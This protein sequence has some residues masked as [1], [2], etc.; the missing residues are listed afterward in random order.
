[1]TQKSTKNHYV[2]FRSLPPVMVWGGLEKLMLEWFERIDLSK[3]RVTLVVST[4][5]GELYEKHIRD[6]GL[7]VDVVEFPF[8]TDFKY[9]DGFLG[10]LFKTL[11]LLNSL[12]PNLVMFFQ[13]SFTDFDLAHVM[14]AFMKAKGQVFMHENLGAPQPSVKSS[15]K[16]LGF[17]PGIALW[18]YYERYSMALR[19]RFCKRIY[20]VSAE[21]RQR[22]I[23]LW[24]YPA[25]KI[26]VMYHGVDVARFHPSVDV[27]GDMR[28]S[29]GIAR[30]DRV[31]ILAARL[32]QEKCIDR[33]I[34]AFDDLCREYSGL[35]L[36][37]AGTGPYEE[38]LRALA[39]GKSS[40]DKIKFLGQVTNVHEFYQMSDIYVLS[41]DNEGL[42]LAFLEAL[43][44]GLVCVVTKC[45]GTTEV[46]EDGVNGFLVEKNSV[47]VLNGLRKA[48][49]LA[50]EK[51]RHIS[52]NAVHFV[53][54]RFEINRNVA[55]ALSKFGIPLK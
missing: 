47:G 33:A 4:G 5:W 19:A 13:G 49:S 42:S 25:D 54:E 35:H 10:R 9:T 17:I 40:R 51:S 29:M 26:E 32:S 52:R 38:R 7:T 36:V 50:D 41:S 21:I 45:T 39:A 15:R 44:S 43:A 53:N 23:D 12:K 30:S 11:G 1:M 55:G 6:N 14:A 46:I 8:R 31:I 48:L 34:N 16:Y 18:W 27:K 20:V 2:F 22:M 24:R 3:C 28:A 37:I